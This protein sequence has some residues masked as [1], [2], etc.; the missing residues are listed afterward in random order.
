MTYALINS[1]C[2]FANTLHGRHYNSDSDAI[3][4]CRDATCRKIIANIAG[5]WAEKDKPLVDMIANASNDSLDVL[6]AH[7]AHQRLLLEDT[8]TEG[9]VT[10]A[11]LEQRYDLA[12]KER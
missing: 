4:F 9:C 1:A 6:I 7:N 8:V 10:A 11:M 2:W 12:D 5:L 3:Q